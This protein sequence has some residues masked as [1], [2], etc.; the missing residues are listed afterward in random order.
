MSPVRAV[1]SDSSD[2]KSWLHFT[3][4]V[5]KIPVSSELILGMQGA[6][7]CKASGAQGTLSVRCLLAVPP[8][9]FRGAVD[10]QPQNPPDLRVA[11]T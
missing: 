11:A 7:A 10:T 9:A 6:R 1:Q 4:T 3:C 8:H 5:D 2:D